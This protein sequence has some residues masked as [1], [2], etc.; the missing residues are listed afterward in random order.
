MKI[1]LDILSIIIFFISYK[2]YGI[3]IATGT[4]MVVYTISV[5]LTYYTNK[6]LDNTTII[7][8]LLVIVLGGL[9]LFLHNA[10]FI[11]YKPTLIYWFFAVAFHVSPYFKDEKSIMERMVGHQ[12]S[13]PKS[14]WK[15][16]NIF[17]TIFFYVL[18][19][20]N[21]YIAYYFSTEQW[22]YFKTFGII[23]LLI[24]ASVVQVIYIMKYI[25]TDGS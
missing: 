5:I 17:W 3:F 16:L 22:V 13:L 23:G 12:I 21:L 1:A 25:K 15:T 20:V 14:V 7:T 8:W 6:K 19:F 18:G 2:Y 11:K 10:E 4:M 24:F 9:T